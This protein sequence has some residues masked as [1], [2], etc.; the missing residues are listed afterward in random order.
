M[1]NTIKAGDIVKVPQNVFLVSLDK[2]DYPEA[3]Y[4]ID[5]P[6]AAIYLGEKYAAYGNRPL[7]ELL[8]DNQIWYAQ[9]DEIFLWRE[10]AS[11]ND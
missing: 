3:Y 6:V 8:L 10:H 2:N 5:K 4:K 1:D 11:K 7:K 9:E